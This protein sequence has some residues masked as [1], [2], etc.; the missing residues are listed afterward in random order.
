MI[1]AAIALYQNHSVTEISRSDASAIN[2]SKTS[3]CIDFIIKE[4]HEK[5]QKSICFVTGVPGAGKTLV[6]LNIATTH[7]DHK[8]AEY[9]VFL[10]GNGPLV[11]VLRE[12]LTRNRVSHN[13]D[14]GIKTTK[15]EAGSQV[16]SF[17]QNVHH[18]RDDC[19]ID[20]N[21]PCNHVVIFDEAQRAWNIEMT[22]NFMKTKKQIMN[23]SQSEPSF[24]ISCMDRHQD[25]A[26]IVCLVGS[27]QEINTGESGI[28][29]WFKALTDD[30]TQWNVFISERLDGLVDQEILQN[31]MQM[32]RISIKSE[33]HLSVSMRS[34]RAELVSDF[35]KAVVDINLD[36]AKL[37]LAS[38]TQRYP[39]VLTRS[40]ENA[41]KWL[42]AKARGSER[43]GVIVSSY[44]E[45]LKPLAIDVKSPVDP[46]HWF[47]NPKDDVRSSYYCEDVAT[48]F[49]IQGLELDWACVTWDADFRFENNEWQH[50]NFKG[51]RWEHMNSKTRKQYQ[52]KCVSSTTNQSQT[53]DGN[54]CPRR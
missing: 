24:L 11:A 13:R 14:I 4:A 25:W 18:F 9:S 53:R 43:Y 48:E 42:K 6:G 26:V 1:E 41:I 50:W 31:L 32:D 3:A 49:L 20:P 17:I 54:R 46:V 7:L 2:L 40:K 33:L 8:A 47:L 52:K 5:H 15:R 36:K 12:A 44:A 10:S 30:Y 45:R 22:S 19:L 35:V 34:F 51:N 28:D 37:L 27:G 21:A 38:I 23:F 16:K 29:E 39:I